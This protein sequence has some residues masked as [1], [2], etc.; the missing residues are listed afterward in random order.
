[1]A[2]R[3]ATVQRSG[4]RDHPGGFPL[5]SEERRIEEVQKSVSWL[6]ANVKEL[7]SRFDE[8]FPHRRVRSGLFALLGYYLEIV[9]DKLPYILLAVIVLMVLATRL[10]WPFYFRLFGY[11]LG[12][13]TILKDVRNVFLIP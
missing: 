10:H 13:V 7:V 1:M 5:S 2:E 11:E 12:K 8:R 9:G 3:I 4:S 6:D